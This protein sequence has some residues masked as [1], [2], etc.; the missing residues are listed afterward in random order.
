MAS[1]FY[2]FNRGQNEFQ[3]TEGASTGSTDVELRVDTGRSLTINEILDFLER[4]QNVILK[5]QSKTWGL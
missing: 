2:G 3:V 4:L 5:N 1:R